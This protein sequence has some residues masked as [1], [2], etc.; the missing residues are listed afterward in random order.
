MKKT[1]GEL[2]T[3]SRRD[4]LLAGAG[5]VGG[6]LLPSLPRAALAAEDHPPVGTWPA[7][8][9]GSSVFVGVSLPRTGTYAVP[10]EDELKGVELALEHINSGDPLIRKIA[11]GLT[12]GLL[13][14]QIE[15]GVADSEAKPN[16]AVQNG[17]KFISDN[18]AILLCG[19]S[20][21]LTTPLARIACATRSASASMPRPPPR[22]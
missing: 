18:K 13:G 12:K 9:S 6:A 14:K 2:R 3:A 7:G 4:V 8:V 19:C 16:T 11:T 5:L 1:S 20:V 22:R 15:H 21:A 10:G 17:T